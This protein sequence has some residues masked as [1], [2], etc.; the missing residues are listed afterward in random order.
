[1]I[2]EGI[3]TT[4][5]KDGTVNVSPM[6][7]Q[8][9]PEMRSVVLRPYDT[10]TTCRNLRRTGE[11]VLHVTDDVELLARAAVGRL[12]RLPPMTPSRAV[13]GWILD[14]AC[15]WYE[16]RVRDI[17]DREPR[18]VIE[19][20]V[21]DQGRQR[22]FF[23][24]NRAMHAVVEAAILATRVEFLPGVQILDDF[25]RLAVLVEKTGGP[26]ER[27]AFAFLDQYVR[28]AIPSRSDDATGGER[29]CAP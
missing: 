26:R 3:V 17:D 22:D 9:E 21:V 28:E 29:P 27:K 11:A 12:D 8:V 16:L 2:L 1:V 15:R 4:I 19:C 24:F 13:E 10:S 7:P 25:S 20:D 14:D 18:R 6:G 5:N 23:G